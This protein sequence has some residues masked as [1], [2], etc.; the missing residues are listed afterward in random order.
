MWM[1][2]H[3]FTVYRL[4]IGAAQHV[5]STI[6]CDLQSLISSYPT[7][8]LMPALYNLLLSGLSLYSFTINYGVSY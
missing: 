8:E 3:L 4:S 5:H 2:V 6:L 7:V 1:L